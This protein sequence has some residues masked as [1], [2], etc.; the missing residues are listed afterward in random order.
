MLSSI[1]VHRREKCISLVVYKM[2]KPQERGHSRFCQGKE[3]I[4]T[5]LLYYAV[6]SYFEFGGPYDNHYYLGTLFQ[7]CKV[8]STQDLVVGEGDDIWGIH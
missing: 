2:E 1:G 4:H 6:D 5:L 8:A 3:G 7:L